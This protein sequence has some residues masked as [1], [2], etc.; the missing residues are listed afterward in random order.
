MLK[1]INQNKLLKVLSL[2][3]ISVAISFVL[4]IL[5]TRIISVYLGSSGMA[6]MGSFR[7]FSVMIKSIATMGISNSIV[8]L[9][10][11]NKSDK[12]ELSIIYST[13]F[14]ILLVV[15]VLLTS[16]ALL[17][18]ET[19]SV[20]LF[21][22][23]SYKIP[24]QFFALLLPLMVIN[25][26]WLAIYNGLEKFKSIVIMQI[27]SNVLIF[28]ATALLI[29]KK[30]IVGGL[31]S[32]AIGELIMVFITFLFV[33]KDT[34]Y[35]KF[36][37]QKVISSKYFNVIKKFI[38]MAL[39][40]AVIAPLTLILIRNTIVQNYSIN[41]AG[42]WDAVN[43]FSSF[44]MLFF[45]TGLSLYYMPKL[46]SLNT[47]EEF[48]TELKSYFK[49]LVPLFVIMLAVIF[50]CKA[51]I[52]RFV[53]SNEFSSINEL[54]IWQLAGDFIKVITLAFGFQ[55]VVKTMMK[56]YFIGE[57]IF[58]L[59]YFLLSY[60]LLKTNAVEGVLQAYFY[61][62]LITF[63]LILFMFRKLFHSKQRKI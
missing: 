13:F 27:I 15:S 16:L 57:I 62:N 51:L 63:V 34:E 61:A 50:F 2:N 46:A 22:S 38:L 8:K 37:L 52:I 36:D 25:T 18:S 29:W 30:N 35:F 17:F 45:N 39:L 60:Y 58:N 31:L 41:E 49:T 56:K 5:S 3:S 19:I 59:S 28:L 4:G 48:K 24:I 23:N 20:F 47:D 44:Y 33:V 21:Y 55:I 40:S 26:F 12:K 7:N 11:E 10:V 54:L 14:W 53:F 32:I 1:L 43:R 6:L 9:F 42:V